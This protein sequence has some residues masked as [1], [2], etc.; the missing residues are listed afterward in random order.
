MANETIVAVFETP[1]D[2]DAAVRELESAGLP[3]SAITLHARGETPVAE[4]VHPARPQHFLP[5]M[6]GYEPTP[7]D[8]HDALI[9]ER[10]LEEG[11]SVVVVDGGPKQDVDVVKIL[12][13]HHPVDMGE[14]AAAYGATG[15]GF[16]A[17]SRVRTYSGGRPGDAG[18]V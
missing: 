18:D 11:A 1:K 8:E 12:E 4:G 7:E 10:S 3:P 16:G 17:S 13:K 9:Y 6:F 14:R 15:G 5:R 2:A